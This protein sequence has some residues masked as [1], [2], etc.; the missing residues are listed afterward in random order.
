MIVSLACWLLKRK[1]LNSRDR[2]RLTNQ[3][4]STVGALPIHASIT[5]DG[6]QLSI[7]GV[8]LDGEVAVKIRENASA[9]LHNKALEAVFE[10]TLYLA[11]SH[12]IHLSQ[13][14]DQT[15]FA[16]AAIWTVEQHLKLLKTL[17]QEGDQQLSL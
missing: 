11:V 10:Q 17:A 6:G 5:V 8:P 15:L 1:S 9:A 7:N 3:V 2:A 4:L 16:K 13:N 12:G 14:F